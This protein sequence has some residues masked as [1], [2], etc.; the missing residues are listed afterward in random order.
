MRGP[1]SHKTGQ[2][3]RPFT[4]GRWFE[5]LSLHEQGWSAAQIGRKLGRTEGFIKNR[6]WAYGRRPHPDAGTVRA[7]AGH[8]AR[9]AT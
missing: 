7:N 4:V 6:L 5:M 1:Q 2:Q 9:R 8:D 3:E